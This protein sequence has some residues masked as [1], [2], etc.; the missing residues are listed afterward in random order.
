[1]VIEAIVL[2]GGLGTRLRSVVPDVP[3][4]MAPVAGQP[5]LAYLLQYLEASGIFRVV[6]AVGYR[7]EAIRECFGARYGAVDL[8]YSVEQEP[9]GTGGA[10]LQALS[11]IQGPFGFCAQRRYVSAAGVSGD[12]LGV[13]TRGK[14]TARSGSAPC[15]GYR[16]LRRRHRV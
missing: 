13:R 10:L 16:P 9:L 11:H 5:F 2:A 1:V 14:Y 4:P 8:V 6:L 3:K 15:G 7:G 12:G